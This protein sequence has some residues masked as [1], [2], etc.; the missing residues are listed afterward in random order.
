MSSEKKIR[1][2]LIEN[3]IDFVYLIRKTI[4]QTDDL[5]FCTYA[6]NGY[7]GL[8]LALKLRPDIV[9]TDLNLTGN[10][11]DGIEVSRQIRLS[12][13]AKVLLLTSFEDPSIVISASKKSFAC[14]YI[15]KSQ[16]QNL[17]GIIRESATGI[18]V[19]EHFIQELIL[20]DLSSAERSVFDMMLGRNVDILSSEKTIAN[21]KTSV[22]KKLGIKN[23]QELQHIFQL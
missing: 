6:E 4:E 15:F 17:C 9:L 11:L 23:Q 5:T 12:T 20:K 13:N 3:D 10:N 19:Q 21:Q 7:A 8:E 16:C 2:L 22:F 14:G 18:T 1:I